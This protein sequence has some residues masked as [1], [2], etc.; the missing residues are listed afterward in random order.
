MNILLVDDD[1]IDRM[2][3]RRTLQLIDST[4]NIT[5]QNNLQA[6]IQ[7]VKSNH[8]DVI[9]LDYYLP[10]GE[11]K[12]LLLEVRTN[13]PATATA[14]I[15]VSV[16]NNQALALQCIEAGAQDFICKADIT[17]ER[18]T[19]AI[20]H[21]KAR[22]DLQKQ[23]FQSVAE[24]DVAANKDSLTGIANRYSFEAHLT[25][26]TKLAAEHKTDIFGLL[27]IDLDHFKYIND[28]YGHEM[29]DKL[30]IEVV[31]LIQEVLRDGDF[32]ARLGGDEFALLLNDVKHVKQ[33]NRVANRILN[34]F[35]DTLIIE[36]CELRIGAS[37]G[38][39][40]GQYG[41]CAVEELIK[42]ADIAMYQAKSQG[43]NQACLFED[44]MKAT[45]F[46]RYDI[47]T[48]LQ[49]AIHNN[50]LFLFF[51]PIVEPKSGRFQG[52]EALIRWNTRKE[53]RSPDEFIPVAEESSLIVN[54]G[55]WVIV[56]AILHLAQSQQ[57]SEL[58][59][60]M[61][62]NLSAKQLMDHD[63]PKY[64]ASCLL[65]YKIDAQQIEFELTETALLDKSQSNIKW[66]NQIKDLG[67]SIALDDFGTGY[68]SLSH[69]Q[70]FPI[71]T[72]KIDKSLIGALPNVK[73]EKL[74]KGMTLMLR[75]LDLDIV[76]E[77][78]ETETQRQMCVD[79]EIE[80]AQGYLFSKPMNFSD[81][82]T[83]F[84]ENHEKNK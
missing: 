78:V 84:I 61:S 35:V 36:E 71:T 34:L 24:L 30:L 46:K 33:V 82:V 74:L 17:A 83:K 26:V 29:G 23:L 11:G 43:R 18:L 1:M 10:D 22:F 21:S 51:Q 76:A 42:Y 4:C 62:I 72:V 19:Q 20:A 63:L 69:L 66:L 47:E 41:F 2:Q 55:R 25:N 12:E 31:V 15:L 57:Q 73:S 16:E 13:P 80:K 67:C 68:S 75:C 38:I 56:N 50:Q 14:I 59:L 6:A 27:L 81:M 9:I 32:F 77:G 7:T 54:I 44:T 40:I 39:V 58:R 65:E 53:W 45:F 3:I 52:M 48:E 64:I 28:H 37:I 70:S 60:N 79:L 5:E 49:K 8:Y